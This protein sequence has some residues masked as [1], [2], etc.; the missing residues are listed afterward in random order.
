VY[1][2][3]LTLLVVCFAADAV[4][5]GPEQDRRE[6]R[7]LVVEGL[8]KSLIES[9]QPPSPP[10]PNSRR[11]APLIPPS[12]VQ[13]LPDLREARTAAR[14]FADEAQHLVVGMSQ[15]VGRMPSLRPLFADAVKIRAS[16]EVLAQRSRDFDSHDRFAREFQ[17][18][19]NQWRVLSNQLQNYEDFPKDCLACVRELDAIDQR[20][21]G[22]LALE[23]QL[24]RVELARLTAILATN[25]HNM[26][27]EIANDFSLG[28]SRRQMVFD[29]RQL[30]SQCDVLTRGIT[31]GKARQ[32]ILADYKAV[33]DQWNTLAGNLRAVNDR[34][35][36]NNMRRIGEIQR[37]IQKQL[38]IKPEV[39]RRELR[40][41]ARLL[42]EQF[43]RFCAGVSLKE[44]MTLP[45][46]GEA[47]DYVQEFQTTCHR[48][49]ASAAGNAGIGDLTYDYRVLQ[50]EWDSV[51]RHCNPLR[52]VGT[53]RQLA[54]VRLIVD[55]LRESL[56][57]RPVVD[58]HEAEALASALCGYSGQLENDVQN[59][60]ARAPQYPPQFRR[61]LMTAVQS[62]HK[63][64]HEL[65]ECVVNQAPDDQ[66][67]QHCRDL[68]QG[69][70]QIRGYAARLIGPDKV[71]YAQTGSQIAPAL[72]KLQIVFEE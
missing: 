70:G 71:R 25:I 32:A 5:Q 27:E 16:A 56:G 51:H 33:V 9:Q 63:T 60:V 35:M 65:Q 41:L 20:L 1:R 46:A 19:D 49:S 10:P 24:D 2:L 55:A 7:R 57:V 53:R 47:F 38:W 29:C 26:E 42:D 44:L 67:R 72:A 68:E 40:H 15:A 37:D 36:W 13:R 34:Y 61:D 39:D 52:N 64:A 17:P 69:F 18:L 50:A 48:F 43:D 30:H 6:R 11:P 58:Y 45:N 3:T 31:V 23:P 21:C 66:I 14:S 54:D 22:M 62:F 12:S 59:S 28:N 4:A 8:F